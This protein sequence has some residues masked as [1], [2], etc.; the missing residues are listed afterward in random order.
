[1][2]IPSVEKKRPKSELWNFFRRVIHVVLK[3]GHLLKQIPRILWNYK[4]RHRIRNS[5]PLSHFLS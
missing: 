4:V 3:I 1:M 2:Q 5:A